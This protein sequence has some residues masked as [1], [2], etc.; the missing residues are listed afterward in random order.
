MAAA[1]RRDGDVQL[2]I[3]IPFEL[4]LTKWSSILNP[5]LAN[6][7]NG[8]SLL[9]NIPLVSGTNKIPHL[10]GQMQT[11]WFLTDID[12]AAVI[13]RNQPF[14]INFLFLSSSAPVTVSLGV[15]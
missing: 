4:M 9:T 5:F 15:F 12:G 10:L 11:G 2:P 13:Y 7:L 6:T 8:V 14:N 3:K 1:A